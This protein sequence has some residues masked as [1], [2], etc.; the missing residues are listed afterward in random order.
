[1]DLGSAVRV[2]L[3][4]WLVLV[5]GLVLT[6]GAAAYFYTNTLPQYQAT[7]RILLLLPA[8]A[9]GAE[10]VDS[11]FLYLPDGLQILA[12]IVS[13]APESRAFQRTMTA[14]GLTSQYEVGID[15]DSP[16]ITISVEGPDAANVIATRDRVIEGVQDELLTVQREEET[17]A[18]QLAHTRVYAIEDTPD[19]VQGDR[20]R[21]TLTV[22]G[23]GGLITLLAVFLVDRAIQLLQERRLRQKDRPRLATD[24]AGEQGGSADESSFTAEPI[25]A[26][27]T[28]DRGRHKADMSLPTATQKA[29][30]F[31][32]GAAPDFVGRKQQQ[33]VMGIHREES[34]VVPETQPTDDEHVS[35]AEQG[36][37]DGQPVVGGKVGDAGQ[38]SDDGQPVVGGKVGDAEQGPEPEQ[39][40][41]PLQKEKTVD[42]WD[43]YILEHSPV[44]GAPA[45]PSEDDGSHRSWEWAP[46]LRG[47]H[48]SHGSGGQAHH[49]R[50]DG[51]RAS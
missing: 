15:T 8:N 38:G 2:L 17:P 5:V 7:A 40:A 12:E 50:A 36:P 37:D 22:L 44:N 24:A 1:M 4:R 49:A 46:D 42:G 13:T 28:V 10:S 27:V 47:S 51:S 29:M 25:L 16:T 26:E 30:A 43:L 45:S 34:R 35:D 6:L 39:V 18:R 19:L 9:R 3:R 41:D 14:T 23:V 32:E 21:G 48:D 31:T 11:S 20:T 33:L